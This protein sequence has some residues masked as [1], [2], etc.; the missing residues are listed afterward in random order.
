MSERTYPQ[1]AGDGT[2]YTLSQAQIDGASL[3][4]LA[5]MMSPARVAVQ[6][7]IN[8]AGAERLITALDE[9]HPGTRAALQAHAVRRVEQLRRPE[10]QGPR[11]EQALA[12]RDRPADPKGLPVLPRDDHA[13][14]ERERVKLDTYKVS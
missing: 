5:E 1:R 9:A 4:D 2:T 6:Q 11:T 13:A 14:L 3:T 10:R 8:P 7:G 12:D